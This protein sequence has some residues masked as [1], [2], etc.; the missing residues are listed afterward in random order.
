MT[1]AGFNID[2]QVLDWA[3]VLQWRTKPDLWD[4]FV[5][6][7]GGETD[8]SQVNVF[9]PDYPGWWDSP[10]KRKV[11][12]AFVTET[13]QAKRLDVWK[14]LHGLFYSEAPSLKIGEFASPFLMAKNL[15]GY[16]PMPWPAFWNVKRVG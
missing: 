11:M 13:D 1:D 8:P 7:E 10:D 5:T 3:T 2:L 15:T 4:A 9:N 14:Q 6:G 16:S 12:N